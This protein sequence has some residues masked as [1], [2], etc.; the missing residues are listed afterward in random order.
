MS[1]M[2]QYEIEVEVETEPSERDALEAKLREALAS[3]ASSDERPAAGFRP[4]DAD[5]HKSSV[6]FYGSE[7]DW[8][9]PHEDRHQAVCA[10]IATVLPTARVQSRWLALD[11]IEWDVT[12]D[13]DD[14]D[15]DDDGP[16]CYECGEPVMPDPDGSEGVWVHLLRVLD[17]DHAPIPEES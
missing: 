17:A 15:E 5:W 1:M 8:A 12:F 13:S 4:A 2:V 3:G 16:H 9:R 6:T 7:S 10:A 14:E 11:H